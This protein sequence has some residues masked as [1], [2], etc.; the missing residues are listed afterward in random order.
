MAA[1]AIYVRAENGLVRRHHEMAHYWPQFLD[2]PFVHEEQLVDRPE[3]KVFW[4]E[5]TGPT[6]G[7]A[8]VDR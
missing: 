6:M 7:L 5:A 1:F 8:P 3:S 4:A 2:Y